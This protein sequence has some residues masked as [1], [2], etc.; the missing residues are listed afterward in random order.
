MFY[1]QHQ[2]DLALST[3]S[4]AAFSQDPKK[5]SFIVLEDLSLED[6]P[7]VEQ[8]SKETLGP[9]KDGRLVLIDGFSISEKIE[10]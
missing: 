2:T 5:A 8:L 4:S 9:G 10:Q 7:H 3:N 6:G 1:Q